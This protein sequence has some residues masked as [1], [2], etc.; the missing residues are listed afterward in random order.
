MDAEAA[1]RIDL[2]RDLHRPDLAGHRGAHAAGH[3]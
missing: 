2:F 1:Q 3:H